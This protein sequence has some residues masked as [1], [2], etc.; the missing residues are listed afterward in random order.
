MP[1]KHPNPL[2][3]L[4]IAQGDAYGAA[5]EYVKPNNQ[6]PQW[7]K[8][9]E[10]LKFT[11]YHKHPTHSLAAGRYTDD[12]QMSIAIA[13]VLINNKPPHIKTIEF[14]KAFFDTFKRDRRDG[15]SRGF[16]AI[17]EASTSPED[18]LARLEPKSDKNGAAMRSVPIGVIEDIC[19]L[20]FVAEKQAMITHNTPGGI[21]SSQAVA[22]MSHYALYEDAPLS[23]MVEYINTVDFNYGVGIKQPSSWNKPVQG[24]QVGLQTAHAVC[25]LLAEENSLLKIMRRL[26]SWG[27]DTDSVAAIAWGI[28]SARYKDELDQ[29]W[30]YNLEPGRM[31]GPEFLK[32]L[33]ARLMDKY[34]EQRKEKTT[35]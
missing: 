22:L 4:R 35:K 19:D 32:Q 3:L 34:N 9:V 25:I 8:D 13:E 10:E 30:E 18:M 31:Y 33:G 7:M 26:I 28:A 23:D 20:L 17:L 11:Q 16:Q 2:M 12:T 29:F 27:G 1:I 14:A 6:T 21:I 15:Y 24:D 5:F